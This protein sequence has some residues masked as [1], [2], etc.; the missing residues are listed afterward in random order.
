[1]TSE[2]PDAPNFINPLAWVMDAAE[3][4]AAESDTAEPDAAAPDTADAET[5]DTTRA[6]KLTTEARFGQAILRLRLYRGWTQRD[7]QRASGVHQ[8]QVS[9]LETATSRGLSMRRVYAIL[10]V[11]HADVIEFRPA[12]PATPPTALELMLWG[13]RWERAGRAAERRRVNRRR[14]A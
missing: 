7:V 10:R 13:D 14:S 4:D 5:S 11:L 8:S 1:M 3:P 6:P 9:R 2:P 12:D